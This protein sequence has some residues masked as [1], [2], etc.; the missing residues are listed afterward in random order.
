MKKIRF[1]VSMFLLSFMFIL[2]SVK[3]QTLMDF[4]VNSSDH[5]TLEKA[6]VKAGLADDLSAVGPFTVF[7]PDIS[8]FAALP[9]GKLNAL[10]ADPF[11]ALADLLQYHV[12]SGNFK[13]TD[14][15][16]GQEIVTLQGKK[17]KVTINAEGVF[18]NNAKVTAADIIVGNG[19]IHVIN[20]VLIPPKTVVD[21]IVKS[22]DH[23][24]L[25][26]AVLAAGLAD[27]LSAAG[28]FTVF[29]PTDAAI[30][31]LPAGTLDA[32]LVNPT[33]ELANILLYHV[34]SG[35]VK[36]TALTNGQEIMTL[37]GK[38]VKVMIN[39]DGVFINNAKVTVADI[40][41]D[42][43]VVHVINAVLI[44]PKTVVDVIVKSPD[45]TTLETAV[46]AAGLADDLSAA[47]P[48]TVFAP[49][50]AA[51][52]SL[53]AGTLDALLVNPTGELANILLY[54]VAS[55]SVKSTALTNGQEIMTL[56]GKKV[57]VMINGDGVFI[58]NAKVTVADIMADNGVVHVIN[59][60][61]IPPKTVVDVIVNSADHT[62]LE[63]AV[64][65]AGLADDL[66]AAGPFTVFAPTDAAFAALPAGTL[67]ALLVNPTGDLANILLYHVANGSV[68]STDL[69]NGQEIMTL[70]GK[71]VKVMI[72]GDGV[73]INNAKVTVADI[74]AD[75]GLVHV[76]NAVLIPPA[77]VKITE[78]E[79]M[80]KVI[81]DAYGRTLYFFTKD[82]NGASLCTGG[83]LTNWP[84]YYAE[85]IKV[86]EGLNAVDFGS[87]DRGDGTMQTTYK[88]WPLYYFVNDMLPGE[89]KGE[90]LIGKW[91]VAKPDYSIMITDNQ[92]TGLNQVNYK[93]D[94]TPGDEVIQYFT[95][96]KGKTLYT[97]TNDRF[98][99]NKFTKPDFSNNG[100]W[101]IYEKSQIVIPSVLNKSD[102][103]VIDVYGKCQLTY[104]GWPLYYFGQ[105]MMIRGNNKGVSVPAPGVWPVPVKDMMSPK[106]ATVVDIIVNS[107]VHNTLEIAV[108]AAGLAD[109]LSAAGP[110]T[111]FA[112]TD[113]AF[114]AL[115]AG[116]LNALL[117]NP[118]GDLANILLYHAASGSVKSTDLTNGQEIM[119]LQGKKVKVMINGDGVFI[120][121]AKVTV[122]N[123]M[124]D[125]GVVHV[126]NAVLIPTTTGLD[127]IKIGLKQ[128][129]IYLNP[130]THQILIS[131]LNAEKKGLLK[132]YNV[133][134]SNIL[135]VDINNSTGPINVSTLI[136]GVYSVVIDTT[137]GRHVGKLIVE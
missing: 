29:A 2:Q 24:T 52:A 136:P 78:T 33:G 93:A 115:P 45:H 43:G 87:I 37:Q 15:T 38:K 96:E 89:M 47:G 104:K 23:T 20:A 131:G 44:P 1:L 72:N 82:A 88:G 19:V 22:P 85:G 4:I 41:A 122:A 54:H 80:G 79:S 102:F 116:T 133:N 126:I 105:D 110:F 103:G 25:E 59:A 107:P 137:E 77:D 62:T 48:F 40:M 32:L 90:G 17:L 51:I 34:A 3:S 71:K 134:G 111:V 101:P 83:C 76:I 118:T 30:A 117:V 28:P 21:V 129:S 7:A 42:N 63:T 121:N 36:S 10:L 92:L 119:T 130:A 75:N 108:I 132:F 68:K 35:S 106:Y 39:G 123:I 56:Q 66:T 73:F 84:I 27:D 53:P 74:M 128:L 46:L 127:N 57:K 100:V 97:W 14:L 49:T 6:V 67:N 95:D 99:I 109:D 91:F 8:A 12:V 70:Q 60:V 112:P 69:T 81:T 61:L 13:S 120:N 86:G 124:A 65:A 98:N 50:D 125:N 114:A 64:V 94:Y 16:N 135:S 31:S 11:G 113:A 55:G 58:N 5:T 26:T 18:I 9:A